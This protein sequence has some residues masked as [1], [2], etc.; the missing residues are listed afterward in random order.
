MEVA[1]AILIVTAI[2]AYV[3]G[4]KV[5]E[6]IKGCNSKLIQEYGKPSFVGYGLKEYKFIFNY[7]LL[8]KYENE[9]I[10]TQII[11]LLKVFRLLLIFLFLF[12]VLVFLL[13]GFQ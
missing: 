6:A 11:F 7:L 13:S 12:G 2:A 10:D 5:G 4:L 9:N 8:K 1:I 3:I